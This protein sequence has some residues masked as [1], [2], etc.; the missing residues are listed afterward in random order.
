M[1]DHLMDTVCV[2]DGEPLCC[3]MSLPELAAQC[4][5]EL[6]NYRR[7]EPCTDTYVLEL[8]RRATI[9]DKQEAWTWVQHCF[10]GMVRRWLRRWSDP[11]PPDHPR[12]QHRTS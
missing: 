10:A 7:G 6:G 3:E 1:V 8:L 4:L 5:R 11:L 12:S 9:Q 2:E